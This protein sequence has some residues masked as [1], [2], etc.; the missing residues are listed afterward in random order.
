[1]ID[2]KPRSRLTRNSKQER[3]VHRLEIA[4]AVTQKLSQ[5]YQQSLAANG[6]RQNDGTI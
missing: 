1:M 6:K 4:D 5:P 3:I 2:G